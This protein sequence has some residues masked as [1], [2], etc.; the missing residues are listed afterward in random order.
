VRGHHSPRS[1]P[2]RHPHLRAGRKQLAQERAEQV[3]DRIAISNQRL[4]RGSLQQPIAEM[5]GERR[6]EQTV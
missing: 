1:R 4:S 3:E 6:N 2:S 5:R